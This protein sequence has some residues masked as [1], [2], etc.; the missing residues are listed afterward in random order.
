MEYKTLESSPEMGPEQEVLSALAATLRGTETGPPED[1]LLLFC[2]GEVNSI[3]II[4]ELF[5][6]F[7]SASRLHINSNK[8]DFYSNGMS[9]ATVD[10][11]LQG[12][13]FKKGDLPFKY[14]GVKISH[15]RLTKVDCNVLV[16][17]MISRI[18][19]WNSRKISYA[20]RLVL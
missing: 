9:P 17:R 1:D 15:K 20:G 3:S 10:K 2:K 8:S 5:K 18:R 4:M 13:G 16:D 6:R 19:G 14:L 7:S 12:T 11:V